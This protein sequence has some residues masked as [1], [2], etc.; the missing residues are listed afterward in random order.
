MDTNGS[1]LTGLKES[2]CIGKKE[3]KKKKKGMLLQT[4]YQGSSVSFETI[5]FRAVENC[6]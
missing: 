3:E 1:I 5:G 4:T 6:F 2:R